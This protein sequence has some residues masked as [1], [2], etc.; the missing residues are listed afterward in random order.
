MVCQLP[1]MIDQCHSPP[2]QQETLGWE[3]GRFSTR[4]C[5]FCG[6]GDAFGWVWFTSLCEALPNQA[7]CLPYDTSLGSKKQVLQLLGGLKGWV[8]WMHI[9]P[10]LGI[11]LGLNG[12]VKN[13]LHACA[14][15]IPACAQGI[16]Q[17]MLPSSF[18]A[19]KH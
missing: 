9:L 5:A 19:G 7:M 1:S 17:P 12:H 18:F 13:M 15:F 14:S 8:N 2:K 3:V 4:C 6:S 10:G 16:A 11:F